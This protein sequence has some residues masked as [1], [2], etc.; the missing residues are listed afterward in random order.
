MEI[1]GNNV[2][3]IEDEKMSNYLRDRNLKYVNSISETVN[4][5]SSFYTKYG[6]RILD[7]IIIIPAIIVSSPILVGLF[8]ANLINMGTPVFYR[9]TRVG[10]KGKTF[11]IIKYRSMKNTVGKNGR[12]I[13]GNERLTKYGRFIR[14]FSLDELGNFFNIL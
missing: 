9:Q 5:K 6:K 2:F 8:I 1:K 7:L 14:R 11:D 3:S 13:P 12:E 4:P 10:F